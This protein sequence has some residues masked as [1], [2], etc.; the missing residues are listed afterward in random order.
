MRPPLALPQ[1][2]SGFHEYFRLTAETDQVA[3]ALGYSFAVAALTL[4]YN[5]ALLPW[6]ADLQ[7]YLTVLLP[8]VRL[9]SETARREFLI[10]PI[11]TALATRYDIQLRV[12]FPLNINPQ[13]RG[14]LDY[15]IQGPEQFV[16]VEAKNE[17]TT[18][19]MTQLMA[20][21][22]AVD[23]WTTSQF[24]TLYGAVSIGTTWQFAALNRAEKRITQ[25]VTLYRVPEELPD[26]CAILLDIL[27]IVPGG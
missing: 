13:L 20:E 11:L 18:R 7:E 10:S 22:I 19:A 14:S 4:P 1:A 12:E 3:E 6:V 17:D 27:Q 9:S 2:I 24:P 25:D 26:L 21:L 16:I 8:R 5:P 15:F 23:S